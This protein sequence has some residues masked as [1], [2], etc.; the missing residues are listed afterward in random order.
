MEPYLTMQKNY[1][2]LE[3]L[4]TIMIFYKINNYK[5]TK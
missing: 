1:I 3:C 2:K 5:L 4:L